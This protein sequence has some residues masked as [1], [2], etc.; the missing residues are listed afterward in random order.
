MSLVN[1]Q[2][3]FLKDVARL[4][5]YISRVG[6]I[7]SGGELWRTAEQQAIYVRTGKSKTKNSKHLDRL[8]IDINF[9]D[10]NFKLIECPVAVGDYW[11][12]LSD[13]N[14]WGGK[15]TFKDSGH[16]QRNR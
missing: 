7:A 2:W 3:E 15:W 4:T 11:E 16:F 10:E 8:A 13:N 9:F 6:I 14:E 1:E 12:S 5:E